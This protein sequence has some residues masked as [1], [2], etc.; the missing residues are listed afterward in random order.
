MQNQ[1]VYTNWKKKN[2]SRK[3]KGGAKAKAEGFIL[4]GLE[5]EEEGAS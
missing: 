2:R 1:I 3:G 5:V 4:P